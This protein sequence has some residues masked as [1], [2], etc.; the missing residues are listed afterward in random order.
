M[1]T[2]PILG[3]DGTLITTVKVEEGRVLIGHHEPDIEDL[4]EDNLRCQAERQKFAGPMRRI[5]SVSRGTL[6]QWAMEDGLTPLRIARMSGREKAAWIKR[7]L[8]SSDNY[9]FRTVSGNI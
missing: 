5:G 1:T 7:K 4:L 2:R 3:P 8:A 9:K 6:Y